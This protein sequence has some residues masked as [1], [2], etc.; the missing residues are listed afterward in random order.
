VIKLGVDVH[1]REHVV[2]FFAQRLRQSQ[3]RRV[4]AAVPN[5]HDLDPLPGFIHVV[6][7]SRKRRDNI[8]ILEFDRAAAKAGRLLARAPRE[9]ASK[10]TAYP[11]KRTIS[12]P[13][14]SGRG[15]TCG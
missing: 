3:R 8:L 11:V 2:E 12:E 9:S 7:N 10:L 14:T 1:W 4:F 15:S 6:E 5:T 13:F